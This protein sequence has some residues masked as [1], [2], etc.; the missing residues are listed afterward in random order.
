M[1]RRIKFSALFLAIIITMA[2]LTP[3]AYAVSNDT[4]TQDEIIAAFKT[5][6]V[7][8]VNVERKEAGLS[9]ITESATLDDMADVRASE[10]AV[11]FSHTRPNGEKCSSIFAAYSLKYSAAGENLAYG[12]SAAADVIDAWM[13]SKGH[14]AN[15]LSSNYSY[16]GIGYYVGDDGTVYCSQLF[17]TP[18]KK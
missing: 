9:A 11:T 8:L 10:C 5:E 18:S 7:R 2:S 3:Y 13:N 12:Y 16:I 6:V 17:Y 15:I 14:K 4:E 1:I